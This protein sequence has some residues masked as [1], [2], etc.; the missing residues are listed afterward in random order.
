[1]QYRP[2]NEIGV[3][4]VDDILVYRDLEVREGEAESFE[5]FRL[6]VCMPNPAP[7]PST[8]YY[9][10]RVHYGP[11]DDLLSHDVFGE[12][13]LAALE[14]GIAYLNFFTASLGRTHEVRTTETGRP[15]GELLLPISKPFREALA[16]KLSE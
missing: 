3:D 8:H 5:R 7:D 16:K 4:E 1:V 6:A 13:R 12:D 10:C 14:N 15:Y 9:T 2:A 11:H